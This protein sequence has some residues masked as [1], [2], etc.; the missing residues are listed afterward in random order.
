MRLL[1]LGCGRMGWRMGRAQQQL[2]AV[3]TII[4]ELPL[5]RNHH[6]NRS[7]VSRLMTA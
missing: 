1:A 3:W 5:C 7:S 6:R 4:G 2:Q